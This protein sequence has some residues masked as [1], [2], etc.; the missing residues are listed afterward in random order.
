MTREM[1]SRIIAA[2]LLALALAVLFGKFDQAKLAQM[3]TVP[4]SSAV[5]TRNK[6]A[7]IP[8]PFASFHSRCL[9]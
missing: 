3:Q 1:L 2:V 9:A 7:A 6:Y 5:I 8:T 4:L